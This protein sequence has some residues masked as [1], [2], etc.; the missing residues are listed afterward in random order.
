MTL[1]VELSPKAETELRRR[2]AR[3]GIDVSTYVA[4]LLEITAE[5]GSDLEVLL[6]GRIPE[7]HIPDALPVSPTA[8]EAARLAAIDDLMGKCEH[9]NISTADLRAER[10]RDKIHEDRFNHLFKSKNNE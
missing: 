1:T 7:N 8:N 9:L 5:N 4:Q 10:E 2:A 6:S 3:A